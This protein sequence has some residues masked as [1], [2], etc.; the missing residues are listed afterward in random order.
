MADS[1]EIMDAF[2]LKNSKEFSIEDEILVF[3]IEIHVEIQSPLQIQFL[4]SDG[5]FYI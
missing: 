1:F 5:K 4:T 3:S 2:F